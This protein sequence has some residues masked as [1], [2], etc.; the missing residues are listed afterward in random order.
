MSDYMIDWPD[1][2]FNYGEYWVSP[3]PASG[4]SVWYS[5]VL[6]EAETEKAFK[7]E[8]GGWFPQIF[9]LLHQRY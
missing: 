1:E 8:G 7:L 9:L 4:S 6:I 5:N 3:S 2:D